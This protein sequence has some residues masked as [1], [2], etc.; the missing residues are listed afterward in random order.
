MNLQIV[1]R[2]ASTVLLLPEAN[3]GQLGA[4]V[5]VDSSSLDAM[6]LPETADLALPLMFAMWFFW[7]IW[8]SLRKQGGSKNEHFGLTHVLFQASTSVFWCLSLG[9]MTPSVQHFDSEQFT[10]VLR[11]EMAEKLASPVVP[12]SFFWVQGSLLKQPNPSKGALTMVT[13]VP[14][15]F[16]A[17]AFAFFGGMIVCSG[18]SLVAK[19]IEVGERGCQRQNICIMNNRKS[20]KQR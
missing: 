20:S 3:F 14:R 1:S 8:P 18:D 2:S 12:F 19:A 4:K 5:S 9:M 10:T 6:F 11:K 7:G 17:A 13:G 15:K 16:P